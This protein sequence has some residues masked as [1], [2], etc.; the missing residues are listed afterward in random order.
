MM[1]VSAKAVAYPNRRSARWIGV[2]HSRS[3]VPLTRSRS[4]ATL[5][6]RNMTVVGRIAIMETA[7]WLNSRF[8]PG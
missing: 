6:T 1:A 3:R 2:V 4:I 7:M 5:V 8:A